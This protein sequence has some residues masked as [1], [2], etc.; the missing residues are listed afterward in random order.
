MTDSDDSVDGDG[1]GSPGDPDADSDEDNSDV[2]LILPCGE[3]ACYQNLNFSLGEDCTRQLTPDMFLVDNIVA[4]AVPEFYR[5]TTVIGN[6]LVVPDNIL[7]IQ[8][9]GQVIT[10]TVEW[11]GP[12]ACPGGSC[13]TMVEVK[14]EKQ[15]FIDQTG[16]WTVYCNDPF[17]KMDPEAEDYP[18]KPSA[19]QSCGGIVNGPNF[20]GDWIEVR[21]CVI[22]EEDTAK[23]IFREW[24]AESTDGVRISAMDTIL[25]VT[26]TTDYGRQFFLC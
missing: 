12:A 9:I 23:V 24:F 1:M 2:A 4:K 8:H 19:S 15:P 25:R 18:F 5:V 14:K 11:I 16:S 22:G 3:I 13:M 6:G 7:R 26:I 21:D 10:V 17:L 20:A